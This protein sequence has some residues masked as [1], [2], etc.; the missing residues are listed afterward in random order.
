M[1]EWCG[2]VCVWY[3]CGNMCVS[4]QPRARNQYSN[5]PPPILRLGLQESPETAVNSEATVRTQ[6]SQLSPQGPRGWARDPWQWLQGEVPS[7]RSRVRATWSRQ[8]SISGN[9]PTSEHLGA[10]FIKKS[11][12][13]LRKVSFLTTSCL[14]DREEEV[15]GLPRSLEPLSLFSEQAGPPCHLV[16]TLLWRANGVSITLNNKTK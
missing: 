13:L 9:P 10:I 1:C 12:V 6:A 5:L 3:L 14:I 2:A 7:W 8:T 16:V 11:G 4:S 15:R